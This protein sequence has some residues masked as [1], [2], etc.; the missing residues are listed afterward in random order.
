MK[1][2]FQLL[3]TP[4]V[5]ALS[6][7]L[8]TLIPTPSDMTPH[9][10]V[11]GLFVYPLTLA[12]YLSVVGILGVSVWN[13]IAYIFKDEEDEEEYHEKSVE[14]T[15]SKKK[16]Y[17][18]QPHL[19]Q[20]IQ[21]L[22][23]AAQLSGLA[24]ARPTSTKKRSDSLLFSTFKIGSFITGISFALAFAVLAFFTYISIPDNDKL[25]ERESK[26]YKIWV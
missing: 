7:W 22:N 12:F 13:L 19:K 15:A 16:K 10:G 18:Y 25:Y 21:S 23:T 24:P 11:L 4:I 3:F 8:F 14:P 6:V 20:Q 9:Y 1:I 2:I 5:L 17:N 26:A